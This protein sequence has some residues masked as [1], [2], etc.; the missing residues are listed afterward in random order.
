VANR[1]GR[2]L[3][4]SAQSRHGK[5]GRDVSSPTRA[6]IPEG[7]SRSHCGRMAAPTMK[8]I[9]LDMT[10]RALRQ[11]RSRMGATSAG[12]HAVEHGLDAA[13][14]QCRFAR[15][16]SRDHTAPL[17]SAPRAMMSGCAAPL[18]LDYFRYPRKNPRMKVNSDKGL[19]LRNRV[20]DQVIISF[21][22]QNGL[23]WPYAGSIKSIS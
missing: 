22:I 9:C 13:L 5:Y 19:L 23:D 10:I 4:G 21:D 18:R 16:Q 6:G 3:F 12:T 20:C 1:G 14:L 15:K 7:G 2:G 11:R 8:W 17:L